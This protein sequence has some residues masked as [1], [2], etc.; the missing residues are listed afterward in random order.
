MNNEISYSS[1]AE[2]HSALTHKA[3]S[4]REL[5]DYIQD[6][7]S[8]WK[9]GVAQDRIQGSE[10]DYHNLSV[11]FSRQNCAP[12]AAA[13][14][15]IGV[16]VYPMSTDLLADV[17]KYSQEIGDSESCKAGIK[18]LK[19]IDRKYWKW[20][21]FVFVI[22]F[23][24][25]SLS[26]SANIQEYESNLKEAEHFI[27]EFKK[28][29]PHEERAYF[30]EA[31]LHLNQNDYDSA[32][33][34]LN[35]AINNIAVAPQC[36]LRLADIY[37]QL[38]QYDQVEKI[39]KKGLLASIQ[40]QPSASVGYVYYLLAMAMDAKRIIKKQTGM[41]IEKSEIKAILTAYQTADRLFVNEGRSSVA[42]R[43]TIK[44][45]CIIIEMEEGISLSK[46]TTM[47]ESESDKESSQLRLN[48]LLALRNLLEKNRG[49]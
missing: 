43:N 2:I 24:K 29:I 10:T 36:C 41:S 37:L 40:E 19:D 26:S 7:E 23:F 30:A 27:A 5:F 13:I 12:F 45:K 4:P 32:I 3:Y 16:G 48:D 17:I 49:E 15:T 35:T 11:E 33:T 28:Y 22:D 18:Q 8:N 44:S 9:E 6:I 46:D 31:E 21:T 38:G 39:A 47:P 1:I 25:D 20:R 34:V 14:A 42:Y